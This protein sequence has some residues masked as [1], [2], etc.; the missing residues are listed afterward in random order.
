MIKSGLLNDMTEVIGIHLRPIEEAKLGEASA[1]LW[2]SACAPTRIKIKGSS[3]HGARP[4]L[5]I[6]VAEAAVLCVNAVNAIHANPRISHS[7]KVTQLMTGTGAI[8]IIPEEAIV[9]IDIRCI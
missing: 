2:H 9:G 4:H 3:A 1:A 8:N 6:N 5:G 7:I